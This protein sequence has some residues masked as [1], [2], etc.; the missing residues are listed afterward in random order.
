MKLVI[1]LYNIYF[2]TLLFI[3]FYYVLPYTDST[4]IFAI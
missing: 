1:I 3:A 2:F 4:I